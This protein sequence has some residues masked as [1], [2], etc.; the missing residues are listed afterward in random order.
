VYCPPST[1]NTLP[2]LHC[3]RGA[4][5]FDEVRS[6]TLRPPMSLVESSPPWRC[7]SGTPRPPNEW[8]DSKHTSRKVESGELKRVDL[9]NASSFE[10]TNEFAN[11]PF[12]RISP[13]LS[14]NNRISAPPLSTSLKLYYIHRLR[15]LLCRVTEVDN[16]TTTL[17]SIQGSQLFS[18]PLTQQ[19]ATSES[20]QQ[21][22]SCKLIR[23]STPMSTS[24]INLLRNEPLQI[25]PQKSKLSVCLSLRI[26]G[27]W[28]REHLMIRFKCSC[29]IKTC[30][31]IPTCKFCLDVHTVI[32]LTPSDK[33]SPFKHP[34]GGSPENSVTVHPEKNAQKSSNRN[35]CMEDQLKAYRRKHQTNNQNHTV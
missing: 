14:S 11:R 7:C 4:D 35:V 28:G 19:R 18:F 33:L 5:S 16:F 31:Q 9:D 30:Q 3:V 1:S 26:T 15:A 34:F 24:R 29:L 6:E 32:S 10:F 22:I 20:V 23:F 13:T 25:I 2:I 8:L 12:K 17:F 27:L 21:N